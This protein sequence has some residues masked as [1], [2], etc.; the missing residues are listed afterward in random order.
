MNPT[1]NHLETG[2]FWCGLFLVHRSCFSTNKWRCFCG[3]RLRRRG[4]LQPS[5][6]EV[7][8]GKTGHAEVAQIAFDPSVV[9]YED[10]LQVFW[11]V[12]NPT[13]PNRQGADIGTQYRSVIFYHNEDQKRI[14]EKSK[15]D[16][17]LSG[18]WNKAN[19]DANRAGLQLFPG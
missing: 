2:H 7:C 17:E 15:T 11:H 14:A 10:L 18:L 1:Q 9:S 13:T 3:T 8:T 16:T 6:E 4:G 19:R 5:Y 12:H